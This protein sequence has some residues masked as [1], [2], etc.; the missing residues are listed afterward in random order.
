MRDLRIDEQRKLLSMMEQSSNKKLKV[1]IY[2]RKSREDKEQISLDSQIQE[3]LSFANRHSSYF[4]TEKVIIFS[5]DNVSGMSIDSRPEFNK[6][7]ESVLNNSVKV[8]ISTKIDRLSRDSQNTIKTLEF[9]ESKGTYFIAGDDLGDN[10]AAGILIKQIMW[11]TAEF[12]VRR[13]IEDMMRVKI[14]RTMAG[15]SAGGPANYGYCLKNKQYV[16]DPYEASVVSYIFDSVL[17]G[18]SYQDISETLEAQGI[19]SRRG[20]KFSFSTIH[21]ILTNE[22]NCGINIF[23][24]K[25]KRKIRK[26]I[27]KLEFDEAVNDTAIEDPII[28]KE[29]FDRVQK[30]LKSRIIPKHRK[31]NRPYFLTGHIVCGHCGNSMSGDSF[32]SGPKKQRIR[33]YSCKNHKSNKKDRCPIR[34]VNANHLEQFVKNQILALISLSVNQGIDNDLIVDLKQKD[35]T[36]IENL[37]K[38]LARNLDTIDKLVL[39][40]ANAKSENVIR[41]INRQLS[42]SEDQIKTISK[43]LEKAEQRLNKIDSTISNLSQEISDEIFTNNLLNSEIICDLGVKIVVNENSIELSLD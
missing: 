35:Q 38:N 15:Y 8:V 4:D 10:S 5:E 19:S 3:C 21:D 33:A 32:S 22:R 17:N 6:L 40:L 27:S 29:L 37:S 16:Q 14:N 25:R 18:L 9:F 2:A 41:S 1:A 7:K 13:S 31:S 39:A 23:N 42:N 26:R 36:I 28:T 43:N 12:S 34:Y 24:S 30:L 20:K 11:A